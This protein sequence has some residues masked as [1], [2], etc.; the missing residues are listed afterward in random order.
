MNLNVA[1]GMKRR[2]VH[3]DVPKFGR[4]RNQGHA[5]RAGGTYFSWPGDIPEGQPTRSPIRCRITFPKHA[6]LEALNRPIRS[7]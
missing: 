2:H 4:V 3:A 5:K 6:V 7:R 1:L